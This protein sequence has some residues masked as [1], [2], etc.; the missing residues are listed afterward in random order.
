MNQCKPYYFE[1]FTDSVLQEISDSLHQPCVYFLHNR[2]SGLTKIGYTNDL[3]RRYS[4]ITNN[5]GSK[6]ELIYIDVTPQ[7]RKLEEFFHKKFSEFRR[8]GEWFDF[9][10]GFI[11]IFKQSPSYLKQLSEEN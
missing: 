7:A 11:S 3:H 5:I 9:P 6:P 8:E 2:L 4:E 1:Q 10:D